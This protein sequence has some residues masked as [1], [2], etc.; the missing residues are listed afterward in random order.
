MTDGLSHIIAVLESKK[1]IAAN[2]QPFWTGRELMAV[3][4]Y[5]A[6]QNFREVIEKAKDASNNSGVF[7][8]DHFIEFSEVISTGKGAKNKRENV[9]LSR[10][11]SYLVAMNGDPAK[12][13][14]ATAQ[15]YFAVRTQEAE[16][17]QQ[18]TEDQRRLLLRN[19]VKDGNKALGDAAYAAGVTGPKFG[20][21]HDA[22]YKGLYDG[23]GRDAIKQL[24]GI[25]ADEDLLDCIGRVELA[26]NE[27]RITQTEQKLRADG[28]KG[29]RRAIDTHFA[30]G[31]EVRT[32]MKKIGGVMPETLP[33]EP[34]IKKLK[35]QQERRNKKLVESVA[36]QDKEPS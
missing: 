35:S 28:I 16:Q 1:R 23:K 10:H 36:E 13:E 9:I 8:N 31:K 21:F 12:P 29:E 22:G 17:E 15:N 30:V 6:W 5:T 4:G 27:F 7:S 26:A 25:P 32:A 2:G 24:K 3:L 20:I 34:S 33:A 18:L 19:R 11:A 14:I